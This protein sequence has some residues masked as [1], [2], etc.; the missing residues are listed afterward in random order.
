MK[1]KQ[2]SRNLA[3]T[4]HKARHYAVQALYQWQLNRIAV[5]EIEAQ[6]RIEYDMKG[7]D[8]GY[9]HELLLEGTK[10]SDVLDAIV[11]PLI[12]DRAID[13]LDP[14][15]RSLL[16]MS[17]YELKDRI[18]VPYR[19]VINEAI[20]FA[21]KFGPEDSQKFVNGILDKA[22]KSLRSIEVNAEK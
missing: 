7:V 19:V 14:V 6:F 9:F 18:D 3:S 13:E 8:I 21:K 20:N 10:Q 5:N 12:T 16:R 1:K 2:D 4:R 15:T 22:A 11:E 17:V